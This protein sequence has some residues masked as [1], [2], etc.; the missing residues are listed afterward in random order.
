MNEYKRFLG[1]SDD[2]VIYRI[3][4]DKEKIG[5]WEEVKNILNDL[6][7]YDYGESTYRKKYNTFQRMFEANQKLFTNSE[8][9]LKDLEEQRRALEREKIKFR[10]ER[11]AWQKQNYVDAR[12]EDKLDKLEEALLNISPKHF[13]VFE[14]T[15]INSDNTILIMLQDLHIGATFNS[16]WGEYNTDIA[17]KRLALLL[18]EIFK[19]QERHNSSDCVVVLGGDL[20]SGNIHKSVQVT[21]RENVIDQIKIAIE[22]IS[23]FCYELSKRFSKVSMVSVSGNHTR[24]DKKEDAIHNERLDDIVSYG[25]GLALNHIQNFEVMD[26]LNLD[27][28]IAI[29]PIRGKNYVAV[30]G[31]YDAFSKTGVQNL[32][33]MVRMIPEAVLYG[34]L[35]TPAVDECQGVKMVRGGSLAGSGD[36]FTVERR[37]TGKPSQ[38]VCIC[39]NKG[40]ETYYPVYLDD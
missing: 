21:N 26:D 31:D 33:G 22:L 17:E 27:T 15:Q 16:Y 35:H 23:Q 5:T 28:S 6:L 20:L 37:L 38:M 34:H 1:E 7:G 14:S 4:K 8:E 40:I 39:T 32:I 36:D 3:A 30:H 29:V 10:D 19:I 13:P 11:R 18:S 9:Q 24:I 2:E 25:I 12:A